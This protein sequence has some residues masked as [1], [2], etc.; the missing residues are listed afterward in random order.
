MSISVKNITLSIDGTQSKKFKIELS[1][2][3]YNL[4]NFKLVQRLDEPNV[5][6]FDL[7]KNPIEDISEPQFTVCS[8]II[9]KPVTLNLQ[10]DSI[11]TEIAKWA[12]GAQVADL[13]FDGLVTATSATRDSSQYVVHV[14]AKTWD[15]LLQDHP[16]CKS[17]ENKT[18]T[19]IVQ[20]V[21]DGVP[22]LG[23]MVLTRHS[24]EIEYTVQYNENNYDFLKRLARRYGEWFFNDGM[25][26]L[27]GQIG[28]PEPVVLGYP[29]KD[30]PEY[31]V[32]MKMR[33]VDFKQVASS[34]HAFD[35]TVKEGKDESEKEMNT[36]NNSVYEASV[37]NFVKPT[38]EQ[39]N[40]GGIAGEDS[41]EKMLDIAAKSQARS[42]RAQMLEY[43]GVTY[44]SNLKLG[45]KLVIK[46]NY[47]T[48]DDSN[49]KS[50]VQQDE[51]L[52]TELIHEFDVE[53]HYKNTF[54]GLPA[55]CDYPPTYNPNTFPKCMPSRAIVMD[56][57]DPET[58]G[59]I[60]VQFDWQ[61]QQDES[62]MTPWLRITQ[63][64][65]GKDKGFLFIPEIDE[66]VMVGFE[67]DNAE[68]PY[69]MGTY[70]NGVD[71]PDVK[72]LPGENEVKAIRTKN[73]HTIEFHDKGKG[74]YIRIYDKDKNKYSITMSTDSASVSIQASGNISLNAGK[75]ITMNAGQ[76]FKITTGSSMTNIVGQSFHMEVVPSYQIPA[77]EPIMSSYEDQ[78]CSAPPAP[79]SVPAMFQLDLASGQ[80]LMKTKQVTEE[81]D[82]FIDIKTKELLHTAN[83]HYKL[84]N[85]S[86]SIEMA[87]SN[88][89]LSA[90][91]ELFLQA[92]T[93]MTISAMGTVNMGAMTILMN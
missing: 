8:D 55:G 4:N 54:K 66:E 85:G 57:E 47:I 7:V 92:T 38:F 28:E 70:F 56:N 40:M 11:E 24:D 30:V 36:L 22:N 51:I 10:T 45:S 59:R 33:H 60:R 79:T 1:G 89:S 73:G 93:D 12:Q 15:A 42:N 50:D 35:S 83:V 32:K 34:Y 20:D 81:V 90:G 88:A 63:P 69:I 78:V 87:G 84:T 17:Y 77:P 74:G 67:G 16:N 13:E 18:L 27:F 72:W 23:S 21:L 25:I 43:T 39:L 5:L 76:N 37:N 31:S 61:K 91:A 86:S 71:S 48:S 41:R 44:C 75:D 2:A 49:S 62:M 52:I 46:D 80:M 6:T 64:Y 68:R 3:Q 82:D 58:L 14:E 65:G 53:E 26:L 9:G 19:D 29:S